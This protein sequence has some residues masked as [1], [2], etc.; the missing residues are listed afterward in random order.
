MIVNNFFI[1][2]GF[3]ELKKKRLPERSVDKVHLIYF[4]ATHIIICNGLDS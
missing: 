4:P 1:L 2:N 3:D